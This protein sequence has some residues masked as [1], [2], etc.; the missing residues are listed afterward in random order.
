MLK[1]Y[2][3]KAVETLYASIV[4][5]LDW[6]YSP[7]NSAPAIRGL[8][9]PIRETRRDDVNL[10]NVLEVGD[11][12]SRQDATNAISLYG[13]TALRTL[14]PQ[15]AA[16]ARL[17]VYL[18]HADCPRY[19]AS[20]WLKDRPADDKKAADRV[21]NHFFATGNRGIIRDNGLS[22]LWWL[23]YIAHEVSPTDPLK[24]LQILL[25]RQDLRSALIE[26]PSVSMNRRVLR[27]VYK[28]MEDHWD[29]R[30]RNDERGEPTILPTL[31]VREVFRD[32]MVRLNR[33]GGVVL[34]DAL[35][36]NDLDR[37]VRLEADRALKETALK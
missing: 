6:Y 5:R 17:W 37:L 9:D 2:T 7:T 1:Y 10:R 19:V 12:P 3:E 33:C 27:A 18:C 16:D 15:E 22:R 4:E 25:H 21:R 24:F 35:D 28:I 11:T 36:D 23:G 30:S 13:E 34:L 20:R 32:W 8:H 14:R 26:R 29:S 31:F